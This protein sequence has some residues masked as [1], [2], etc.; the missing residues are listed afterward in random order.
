MSH[1]ALFTAT[2]TSTR[3]LSRVQPLHASFNAAA[4]AFSVASASTPAP[5]RPARG[6]L[7]AR[8]FHSTSS[9]SS[10]SS[11]PKTMRCILIKDGKGPVENLYL[12]EEP[13]PT[14]KAGEV[15]VKV[16]ERVRPTPKNV[17]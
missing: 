11:V 14:P 10:S 3:R 9:S 6:I 16:R 5:S 7:R 4:R 15:Q 12:G 1:R 13:T 17:R 2:T 8:T